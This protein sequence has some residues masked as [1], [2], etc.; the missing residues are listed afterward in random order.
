MVVNVIT[1]RV[2]EAGLRPCQRFG[3]VAGRIGVDIA[4]GS[5]RYA[6]LSRSPYQ[7]IEPSLRSTVKN[8]G[9][10]FPVVGEYAQTR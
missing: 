9:P 2:L 8:A 7:L 1:G 6:L 3:C 10:L 4:I 5:I